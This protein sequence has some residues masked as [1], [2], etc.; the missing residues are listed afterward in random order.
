MAD[1]GKN[2]NK[3]FLQ[4]KANPSK[5]WPEKTSFCLC[6]TFGALKQIGWISTFLV[7]GEH[8]TWKNK[9]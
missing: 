7:I 2:T 9:R 1:K 5:I 6:L 3:V 8:I 4:K